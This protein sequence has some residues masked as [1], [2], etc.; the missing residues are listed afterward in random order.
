MRRTRLRPLSRTG[1]YPHCQALPKSSKHRV[2]NLPERPFNSS[3][4]AG[5]WKGAA[6]Q[7]KKNWFWLPTGAEELPAAIQC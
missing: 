1:H 7:G 6:Q 2:P 5:E 3:F 4:A